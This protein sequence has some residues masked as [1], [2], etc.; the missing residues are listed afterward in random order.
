MRSSFQALKMTFLLAFGFL[1]LTAMSVKAE[2]KLALVIGIDSY[3]NIEPLQKARNDARAVSEKLGVLEF[4][5]T[6]LID[7]T[8]R[9]MNR[10]FA[11]FTYKIQPGDVVVFFFAGHGI[12]MDGRNYLLPADAPSPGP[13][14]K[15]FV[16]SESIAADEIADVFAARGARLTFLILDACRNNPYPNEGA[17]SAGGTQGLMRM[18]PAEGTFVLFS[19]GTGQVALDRLS[20]TDPDPNSVFTRALLPRLSQPGLTIHQLVQD[21]RLDVRNLAE[22]VQHDQFPAYYDQLSGTFSF[23]PLPPQS[24]EP[25]TIEE[26]ATP[27]T[28]SATPTGPC[29]AARADWSVLQNTESVAALRQFSQTYKACPIYT[30]AAQDRLQTLETRS[31]SPAPTRQLNSCQDLWYAR[32]LIYH[33]NGYCFQ[34]D[35]ARSVFDTGSCTT[36]APQLSSAETREVD[37]IVALEKA[38]GC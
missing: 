9:E 33:Q 8:R 14:D 29:D 30:A 17:R 28:G 10:V 15:L 7:P 21:V 3:E 32:N 36:H 19:A 37:R 26:L 1:I 2:Q 6:T 34:S 5:V 12:G 13:G 24:M 18:D 35:R 31:P 11:E 16:A 25:E 23:N 38:Q 20:N 4:E 22:R 27:D